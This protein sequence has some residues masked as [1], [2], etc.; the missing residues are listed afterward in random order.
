MCRG[1]RK[2]LEP[3]VTKPAKSSASKMTIDQ[4]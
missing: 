3:V 4:E 2:I 1:E